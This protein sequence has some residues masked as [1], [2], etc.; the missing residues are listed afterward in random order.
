MPLAGRWG[1]VRAAVVASLLACSGA[2][3]SPPAP[4]PE[5]W[6]RQAVFY[7]VFVRSFAD[8]NGDGVG[9]LAGLTAHLD[10]L[11]D[12]NPSTTSDLGVDA[13]WL[14][15]TFP[16]P[17]YH[18]Y[19]VTDYRGVNPQY[20]TLQDMDALLAA[21]HRRGIKV[22]LDMVLNHS[23]SQH[24][25]FQD[26]QASANGKRDWYVWSATNP[27]WTG[28]TYWYSANGAWYYAY[29]DGSMP[30]LNL[31]NA[32][33]EAE[34]VSDMKFWLARGVDGFRLDAVRY[35]VEDG[36]PP[37]NQ[38]TPETHAFLKR[39]RAA[40]QAD[41][42]AVL[43]VAEAWANATTVATYWGD[44]DEVQLAFS[45]D[46]AQ[47]ILTGLTAATP[48]AAPVINAFVGA[49]QTLAGKDIGFQAPF[50]SNH[51]QIRV[52]RA[53]AGQQGLARVAAATL[54]ALPG[55]PFVYYGEELG[56]Q[57]GAG[58]AD[59]LK[60]TPYPWTADAP[61]HG[62]TTSAT[63]WCGTST[64]L[65]CNAAEAPGVDLATQQ[66]DASSL[67]SQYRRLIALRHA[68]PALAKGDAAWQRVDTEPGVF[69]LLRTSGNERILFVANYG[70]TATG[71]FTIPLAGTAV[72][73]EAVGMAAPTSSGGQLHF[74]PL[75]PGDL[76]FFSLD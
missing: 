12:G 68:H 35:Y 41:Y 9:D 63:L 39:I 22:I 37:L 65:W 56:M 69:A 42:P 50:L 7:E 53:L 3:S 25:W 66:A 26:S 6:W 71:A 15:P 20:G 70:A 43:L 4:L 19:D 58:S 47:A 29:F 1:V 48:S 24:P 54:F 51:D 52:M 21:A 8:S 49:Q 64:A 18:G 60:R 17:S 36:G 46:L 55:T 13:I 14:M 16:S 40:L 72:M 31:R 44:G 73:L 74:A 10:A 28:R 59:P 11:N 61:G 30:D 33:V 75:N 67:W 27:G 2:K 57:G 38:D 34:L 5:G 76:G 23:S 62:F 32:D 45:F